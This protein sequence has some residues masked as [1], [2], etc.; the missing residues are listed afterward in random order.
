MTYPRIASLALPLLGLAALGAVAATPALAQTQTVI[1]AP[2]APPAAQIE[3]V[4]APPVVAGQVEYWTPGH[5]TW[6]SGGWVWAAGAYVT[7]PAP[8]AAWVPGQW[9]TQPSGGYVWVDGH[10]QTT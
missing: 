7:A 9:V 4:P 3:V 2:S 6:T 5:W 1:V 8:T 10:W